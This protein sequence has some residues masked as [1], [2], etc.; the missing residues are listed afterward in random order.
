M[1]LARVDSSWKL[2]KLEITYPKSLEKYSFEQ[3]YRVNQLCEAIAISEQHL[4]RIVAR[5]IG[6][7]LKKW[8]HM[9][10]MVK[11]RH[12]LRERQDVGIVSDI[13]GYSHPNSFR[14]AFIITYGIQPMKFLFNEHHKYLNIGSHIGHFNSK[15]ILEE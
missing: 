7:S 8:M 6:I 13:L 9:E 10:R 11:A 14:R 5:D 3:G 4:R 2:V 1:R 12:L 15:P